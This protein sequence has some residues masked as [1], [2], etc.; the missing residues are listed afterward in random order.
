MSKIEVS[1]DCR[2]A[3]NRLHEVMKLLDLARIN[4]NH[5]DKR[6]VIAIAF[7]SLWIGFSIADF[8]AAA[9]VV[10]SMGP[11]TGV[12][13]EDAFWDPEGGIFMSFTWFGLALIVSIA[14]SI[15]SLCYSVVCSLSRRAARKKVKDLNEKLKDAKSVIVKVCPM[16]LWYSGT[17]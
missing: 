17:A 8:V 7:F 6:Y 11:L 16:E 5:K 4:L 10:Y 14:F 15:L 1:R 12:R 3:V 9:T 2:D 13:P